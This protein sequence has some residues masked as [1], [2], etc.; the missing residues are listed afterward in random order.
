MLSW[1]SGIAKSAK[2]GGTDQQELDWDSYEKIESEIAFQQHQWA[3]YNAKAKEVA[4]IRGQRAA[5]AKAEKLARLAERRKEREE[6]AKVKGELKKR[7]HKKSK[8]EIEQLA[9][10]RELKLKEKLAKVTQHNQCGT[11][12]IFLCYSHFLED[13][14]VTVLE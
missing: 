12:N 2:T 6:K 14:F 7:I 8:E 10:A 5:Q 13:P 11:N 1:A 4:R 9:V 3:V